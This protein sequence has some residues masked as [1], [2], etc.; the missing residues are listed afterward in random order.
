MKTVFCLSLIGLFLSAGPAVAD[1]F[2]NTQNGETYHGF[3]I[4]D[5]NAGLS[6]VNTIEKGIIE[7]NLSQFKVTRDRAGRNNTVALLSVPDVI[8]LGMETK[9]F[10]DA[11]KQAASKG[12][13]FILIEIDC[14]GGRVDLAMRM[15]S[16]VQETTNCNTY[17][18]IKGG[19]CGGAYSAAVALS[20]S[21]DKIYMSPGTV[22]GAA[23]MISVNDEGKPV[24]IKQALGETVGEKMSSGWRNYL[25]SLA[26]EKNRPA[27]LAKAMESKD[28]EA[29]EINKNGKRL[30]IESV[31]KKPD[32]I[33][34]KTWSKKDSILTLTAEEAV[35]C[36][37]ADKLYANRQDLLADHNALSAQI[38]PDV[39][40]A[41]ARE[42]YQRIEKSL[43]R[44]NASIDLGVKQLKAT[45]SRG[46]ALKAMRNIINDAQFVLGLKRKFGDDVPVD[47]KKVQD[48]LNDVKAEYDAL[49][50]AR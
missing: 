47:E 23:T 12:P 46:Q 29:I 20:L 10:E 50:T 11:I 39:S 41:K 44:I 49:R 37:M 16:A 30:F 31:N 27:V 43:K 8:M 7:V 28:I 3:L 42:I 18:Y 9:A 24:E 36:G 48:Y 17:A 2:V 6:D 15:C 38:I 4:G 45:K 25:A 19:T 40:M 13:L 5:S 32:D 33:V 22:I 14:P 21:C 35:E 26:S 34:V 1:T